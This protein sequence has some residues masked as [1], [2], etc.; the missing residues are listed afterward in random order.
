MWFD[1]CKSNDLDKTVTQIFAS[2]VPAGITMV[3]PGF[4]PTVTVLNAYVCPGEMC[5][6]VFVQADRCPGK[7]GVRVRQVVGWEVGIISG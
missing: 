3:I 2:C 7:T 6:G 5:P 1:L 4:S